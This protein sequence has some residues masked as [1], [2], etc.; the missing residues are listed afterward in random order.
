MSVDRPGLGPQNGV[1][2]VCPRLYVLFSNMEKACPELSI[3]LWII[4]DVIA[5]SC[6]ALE[7]IKDAM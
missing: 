6:V 3:A 7:K 5:A 2:N 1:E 4:N